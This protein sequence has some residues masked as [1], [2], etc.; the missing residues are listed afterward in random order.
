MFPYLHKY[1]IGTVLTIKV[2]P[3][4]DEARRDFDEYDLRCR[5]QYWYPSNETVE[6]LRNISMT[7]VEGM[8]GMTVSR[9]TY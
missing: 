6:Q 7:V 2:G 1:E 4:L 5:E 9:S 3:S 8:L